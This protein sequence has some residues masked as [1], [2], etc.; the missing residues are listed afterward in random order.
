MTAIFEFLFKYRPLIYEKGD[1]AF[2]SFWPGWVTLIL[3]AAVLGGSYLLYNRLA[4]ALSSRW[5][6]VL[7]ALRALALLILLLIFLQPVLILH[8]VIPQKSFVAIAYDTSKSMEIRDGPEGQSRLDAQKDLLRAADNPLLDELQKKFKVRFFRF[9]S[10]A[11]RTGNY[12]DPTRHGNITDFERTLSQ[13]VGDL[14][15]APISGIVLVTDG[16]DNHSANLTA[17]AAQ[18]KARNIPIYPVGIGASGFPR[19]MEV[20]RVT[21]PKKVLKDTVIE[22][23]VTVRAAGYAGR[24]AKL[25]VKDGDRV[26]QSQEITLGGD[27]EVKTY[28]INFNSSLAGPQVYAFGLEPFNDEIVSQNND[29]TVL[30]RVEDEQPKI[31]YTEG[32]P[33]W[34]YAFMRRSVDQDKN[35]RLV[36]LLRQADGKFLRQGVDSPDTLEKGFPTDKAELFA[37]KALILGS[38]EASFFTFDQLRLISDFV[39]QRGG[40]LLILGGQ[41]SFGQGGYVNTPL[42]DLMP[43][44]IRFGAGATG[45]PDFQ[46][47]EFKARLSSYGLDHPVTRLSANEDENR[48]RWDEAPTLNGFNPTDGPKPGATVLL[49]GSIPDARGQSPVILAFQRFGR[50]KTV[51]LTTASTWRWKM[52]LDH[53]DNFHDA[54]WK[55]MLRW[56]VSDSPDPVSLE[57]E[58]HSYSL[59]ESAVLRAEINGPTFV[60]LNNTQVTA[61][62]KAPSGDTVSVPLT[63]EA[64]KDGQYSA[65]YKPREEGIHEVTVEALQ[66]SKRIGI[67]RSNFRVADSNEEFHDAVLNSDLL[68]H[69]AD[70]TGGHYYTPQDARTMPEDISYV[71][72]G[73][74]RIEERELWDMP[75]LFLLMIGAV[76]TEWALRKRKGLA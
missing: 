71:D 62:I 37:Y 19:D 66:G 40:G 27:T 35:L 56:L 45:I 4:A 10:A 54:F 20:L 69:L 39:S 36:T 57:T 46:D 53:L 49:Q 6:L 76:S 12:E 67:A 34:I 26:L 42:E 75:F 48:K 11:D 72:N 64:D 41:H 55:E 50:G 28:K 68:Q 22:A 15:A 30:V 8:S 73:A 61:R 52:G 5:R 9:S 65:A 7:S 24:R 47:L 21:T 44:N 14:G 32:E 13:V 33:R 25:T 2:R 18:L 43:V 1:L 29:Q 16:A 58:K 17:A 23:D 63:W 74:S 38:V 60:R 70:E 51:A 59:D 3:I 31:L